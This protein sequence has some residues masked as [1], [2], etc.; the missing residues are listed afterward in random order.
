[1]IWRVLGNILCNHDARVKVK[2]K[3]GYLRWCA[4]DCSLVIIIIIIIIIMKGQLASK[5]EAPYIHPLDGIRSK[6]GL[7]ERSH[8]EYQI[9]GNVE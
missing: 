1:M 6:R 7:S 8:V 5:M 2:M 3:I 4:I 9:E